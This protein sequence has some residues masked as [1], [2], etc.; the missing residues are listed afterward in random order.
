MR[1]QRDQYPS[2]D[3]YLGEK[4]QAYFAWQNEGDLQRGRINARKFAA[5]VRSTDTVIDFGC[6]NG[7][8]LFHL[9]SRRR[10]GVE[11]NPTARGAAEQIGTE[12]HATL[13]TVPDRSA[14]TAISNHALEHTL[15]PYETLRELRQKLLPQGRLVLCV[16][17]DD[18]RTEK[19]F[20]PTD[21]NHHLYTWSPLLL[22]NLL[23]EAGYRVERVWIYTHA[24]PPTYWRRLD[25]LLPVRLFDWVCAFTA[26]RLKWRQIMAVAR[27]Q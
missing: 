18:W 27:N 14:N 8:L 5:F 12:V 17:I 16:P 21:V 6:G 10:I 9:N 7:S 1:L 19:K 23:T 20:N 24:W 15:C 22:G 4:G 11:V 3:H 26:W 25:A 13:E 2:S